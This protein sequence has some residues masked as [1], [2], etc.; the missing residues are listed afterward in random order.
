[1][2]MTGAGIE[3]CYSSV[4][5]ATSINNPRGALYVIK[6]TKSG[7]DYKAYSVSLAGNSF[8]AFSSSSSDGFQEGRI[9]SALS[10]FSVGVVDYVVVR[11]A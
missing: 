2:Q 9:V 6:V 8:V 3:P 1:M 10:S 5:S 7:T 4:S 11:I